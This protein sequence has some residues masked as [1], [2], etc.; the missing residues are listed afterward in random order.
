MEQEQQTD[1]LNSTP[2]KN[3]LFSIFDTIRVKH[4][5]LFFLCLL[6]LGVLIGG[7]SKQQSP[8]RLAIKGKKCNTAKNNNFAKTKKGAAE[9]VE[10]Y[11]SKSK[12]SEIGSNIKNK[13]SKAV[14]NTN[15]TLKQG[16]EKIEETI[17]NANA[18]VN[19]EKE[20]IGNLLTGKRQN[21][22]DNLNDK[23][24]SNFGNLKPKSKLEAKNKSLTKGLENN[25]EKENEEN[26]AEVNSNKRA[27]SNTDDGVEQNNSFTSKNAESKSIEGEIDLLKK[28]VN[29]LKNRIAQLGEPSNKN[30]NVSAL[31]NDVDF[32]NERIEF[33][34]SVKENAQN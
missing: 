13:T 7:G 1:N 30:N 2:Q 9:Q 3:S 22:K 29:K 11:T 6:F 25:D 17:E 4:I 23:R 14:E 21:V 12:I 16:K 20:K 24:N 10:D 19:K 28:E 5:I 18:N 32:I 26:N 27:T 15:A 8:K 33:W 34:E 31:P